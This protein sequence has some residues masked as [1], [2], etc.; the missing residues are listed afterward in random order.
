MVQLCIYTIHA[1]GSLG[2]DNIWK[3][4]GLF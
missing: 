3:S 2:I 4:N 1:Q